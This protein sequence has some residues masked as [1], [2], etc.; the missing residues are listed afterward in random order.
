MITKKVYE[1]TIPDKFF[2]ISV[3][4]TDEIIKESDLKLLKKLTTNLKK[5]ECPIIKI[6]SK[7]LYLSK[8]L[9]NDQGVAN[10]SD[11]ITLTIL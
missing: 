11:M 10:F 2:N 4:I 5:L 6:I 1:G 8:Q 3:F 9:I 7:Y